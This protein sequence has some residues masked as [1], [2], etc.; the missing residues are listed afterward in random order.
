LTGL[1]YSRVKI[2]IT[3]RWKHALSNQRWKRLST[4]IIKNAKNTS[5]QQPVILFN[6]STRLQA[7]S[8]NAAYSFLTAQAL[9]MQGIPVIQFVC[10]AGL[11]RCTLGSNRD[12]IDQAPPCQKCIAQSESVFKNI[13]THWF[14]YLADP[15]L[16]SLIA[17]RP[18]AELCS[19]VY[20]T[21]PLGFWAVNTLRWVLRRHHLMD[22]LSTL[23]F[24][25]HFILSGWNVYQQFSQL[26]EEVRPQAVVLFNGM[27]FPE[28]AARFVCEQHGIRVI[29]HE[30]GM[31]P[32]T[33]FFTPGEATAYP[34]AISPDFQLTPAMNERL[35]DYL[36][37]RFQGNFSM[38]GIRFWPEMKRLENSF[39]E[40][41]SHFKQIV[42]IFTNV[43]FDTSQ[44][45]A[46]TLFSD[47][48]VWLDNVKRVIEAHPE[49]LFVIRAHPDE[50]RLGKEARESVQ[51][52]VN[53]NKVDQ[54][55]NVEFVDSQEFIS[56]YDL[57][58]R[59]HFV[60][61]YNSTIGLEAVLMG[62]PVLAGGKAR[63]TQ[64]ETAFLPKTSL[65]YN[66]LLEELLST[67]EIQVPAE[68]RVN[69]RRFLYYQLYISSL[70]FEDFLKEDG[71]WKG[72]VTLKEF[73][74]SKLT[75]E[76]SPT[77]KTLLEG[78]LQGKPFEL[79]L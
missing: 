66:Q 61:V 71:V 19:L 59:A 74:A 7:M 6:A 68:F 13:P 3:Q 11:S 64:L 18:L 15:K 77:I 72:Y 62:K 32:F 17:D 4:N 43:I 49:T 1:K 56:S 16:Q 24:M 9:R 60:M 67:S 8:Q 27:F 40:K 34:I 33:A 23:A 53:Q 10:K 52:W 63:F 20:E 44:V 29:T 78:I 55:P 36:S 35:D 5:D 42:P 73:P 70:P 26:A 14:T 31:R 37:D 41:A 76:S 39:L 38:A 51:G 79:L 69:A 21:A 48:F 12:H 57:T 65:E 47:M 30:V 25:R 45:H 28:A 2:A 22:D 46:N 54:L 75:P 50:F 58:Q